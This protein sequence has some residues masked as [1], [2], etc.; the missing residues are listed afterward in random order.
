MARSTLW[1][2]ETQPP[3]GSLGRPALRVDRRTRA[4][5]LATMREEEGLG[6]PALQMRFPDLARR[7]LEDLRRRCTR[8]QRYLRKKRLHRLSWTLP[9]TVWAMDHGTPPAP[10]DGESPRFLALR[11]LASSESLTTQPTAGEGGD[12]VVQVLSRLFRE[13][14]APL[15]LKHDGGPGFTSQVVALLCASEGVLLLR[16]PPYTPSYNGS[17][18]AGVGSA[19]LR[20]ERRAASQG[21]PGWWTADDLEHGRLQA[22]ATALPHGPHGPTPDEAWATRE[23]PAPGLRAALHARYRAHLARLAQGIPE[24]VS[25]GAAECA[26]VDRMAI[27]RALADLNLLTY[28]RG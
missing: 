19:K 9:G 28:R 25:P 23:P 15:V 1:R 27:A 4:E 11:D 17:I 26:R 12:E 21:R 6:V 10:I 3:G 8:A 7:E 22:N 13:H 14:G 16:S 24:G 5:I 20:A 18:E 2:W